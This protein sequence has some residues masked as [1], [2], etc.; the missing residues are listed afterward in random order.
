VIQKRPKQKINDIGIKI[1]KKEQ[2]M[3]K[4]IVKIQKLLRNEKKEKK[5]D[6]AK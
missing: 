6:I 2:F 1:K 4:N 5:K 3:I